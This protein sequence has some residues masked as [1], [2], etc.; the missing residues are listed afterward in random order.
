MPKRIPLDQVDYEVEIKGGFSEL[1]QRAYTQPAGEAM[2]DFRHSPKDKSNMKRYLFTGFSRCLYSEEKFDSE[3]ERR[4]SVIL[5]RDSQRWFKP[6][7]GQFLIYYKWQAE[8]PEYQPDFVAEAA[9][10]VYMFEPKMKSEM[11]DPIVLAKRNAAVRCSTRAGT[12]RYGGKPG[13]IFI[14]HD[15]F[16][17]R[18]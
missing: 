11:T 6:T 9:D 8:H 15:F 10:T 5:D 3:P 2:L 17:L 1:K 13:V 18:I 12:P 16:D 7:R 4:L 14:P